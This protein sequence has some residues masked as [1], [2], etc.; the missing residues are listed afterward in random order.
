MNPSILIIL[1]ALG[2]LPLV[3]DIHITLRNISDNSA[4]YTSYKGVELF[5]RK[6]TNTNST[7]RGYLHQPEHS[8]DGCGNITRLPDMYRYPKAEDDI[9]VIWIAV[10]EGYPRCVEHNMVSSVQLAGYDLILVSSPNDS[11]T[12]ISSDLR[13]SGFPVVII[14]ECYYDILIATALSDLKEPEVLATVTTGM[15]TLTTTVTAVLIFILLLT[16]ILCCAC[17]IW[18]IVR[19]RRRRSSAEIRGLEQRRQNFRRLQSRDRLARQEL[20]ESILRQLQQLQLDTQTQRPLGSAGTNQLP[21]ERY[22][23]AVGSSAVESCAICVDD[24]KDGDMMRVLPCNHHFHLVCIDEWLTNHSDLCPLCKEQVP[25]P[26]SADGMQFHGRGSRNR[27]G[28]GGARTQ[29][30][31]SNFVVFS[32][33]DEDETTSSEVSVQASNAQNRLLGPVSAARYGSV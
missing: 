17:G 2:V 21:T 23:K 30:R 22:K 3:A 32:D 11:D 27:R 16:C 14:K 18:C 33:E 4:N 7:M 12:G 5:K 29:G 26:E 6:F 8:K 25:R 19:R 20:V 15:K 10:L 24:F 28:R 13:N 1:L 9:T 31:V